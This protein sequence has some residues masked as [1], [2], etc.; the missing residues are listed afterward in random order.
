M[1]HLRLLKIKGFRAYREVKEFSF[2][3]PMI[4][5]FGENA[6]GK[7][8]TLNAIEW[9]FFGNEC[10]GKGTGIRERINWKL[11]NRH[12]K[13]PNVSVMLELEDE[14]GRRY[15]ISRSLVPHGRRRGLEEKLRINLPEGSL[16]EGEEAKARL[17][18][19]VKLSF[20]DFITTV[21]Q[22]QEVIRAVL[23]QE[24]R[25]RNDAI[26]RLLGLSDY[27]NILTGIE[28]ARL[29]KE[30]REIGTSFDGF[31]RKVEVALQTRKTDLKERA[32]KAQQKGL[33]ES[34]LNQ[35]EVLKIAEEAKDKLVEFTHQIGLDLPDIRVPKEWKDLSQFEK[36]LEKEIRRFRSE[37]PEVMRQEDLFRDRSG[38]TELREA[39]R[40]E[41]ENEDHA[42][43]KFQD[44]TRQEGTG[45][46]LDEKIKGILEEIG[47]KKKTLEKADTRATLVRNA[48]EYLSSDVKGTQ[49]RCPLCGNKAANLG[50]H[51]REEWEERI[52]GEVRKLQEE[53]DNLRMQKEK[54]EDS[55]QEH[56]RLK[57]VLERSRRRANEVNRRIAKILGREIT[58]RDDPDVLLNRKLDSITKELRELEGVVSS[59]Q[60]IL[61]SIA[62]LL[63]QIEAIVDILSGEEKMK[64]VQEI[65]ASPEHSRMEELRD[66]L[67]ILLDDVGKIKEAAGEASQEEARQKVGAAEK[68]IDSYFRRITGNPSITNMRFSVSVDSRT[69]RNHY[70]FKDQNGQ[71]LAPVLSQGDLNAL[72]LSIFL[73]LA[74]SRVGEGS[75]GFVILDDPSQ[76]LGSGHKEELIDILN[77]VLKDRM[78]ILSSMDKEL[79]DLTY[80]RITRAK[81]RY[82]FSDW[83]PEKG[84][85][86]RKE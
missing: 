67:A 11:P 78:V 40:R 64:I 83:T 48:L 25:D 45:K 20:R 27:R 19:L 8:S 44:F 56:D 61:D 3:R 35:R 36:A 47:K 85:E 84:P 74:T 55:S 52:G 86:V 32:T 73:G 77:E 51:L 80:S 41:K 17:Q 59:R 30:Q 49:D 31:A 24:P 2:E 38:I 34:Q 66:E 75:F 33:G 37:I 46:V 72:A 70:E 69:A 58:E 10:I 26:D 81:T 16:M 29:E 82:V 71:D 6:R 4:L 43:R 22:H 12:V 18:Q 76:S 15:V 79:Q 53:I 63:N 68:L 28:G 14:E 57:E 42:R 21:Y 7:S 65:Q 50:E 1:I 23:T 5:L 9:C 62:C 39:S 60:G 54:L 13:P